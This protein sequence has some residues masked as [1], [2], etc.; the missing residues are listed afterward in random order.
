MKKLVTLASVVM[1]L[2]M[3]GCRNSSAQSL[4]VTATSSSL[5][6]VIAGTAIATKSDNTTHTWYSHELS[7]QNLGDAP[8]TVYDNRSGAFLGKNQL[9]AVDAGCGYSAEEV[10]KQQ[11]VITC[12]T[13]AVAPIVIAPHETARITT[14]SAIKGVKGMESLDAGVYTWS[15]NLSWQAAGAERRI[16]TATLIYTVKLTT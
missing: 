5:L 9:L 16:T 11:F 13:D 6:K 3:G 2:L 12:A 4:D 14:I 10:A 7:V 1:T 8:I 15:K